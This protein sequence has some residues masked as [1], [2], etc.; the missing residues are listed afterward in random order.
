MFWSFF[1]LFSVLLSSSFQFDIRITLLLR[2]HFRDVSYCSISYLKDLEASWTYSKN[3]KFVSARPHFAYRYI[4]LPNT[5]IS[6]IVAVVILRPSLDQ[7]L[8]K[9][10]VN[11][12]LIGFPAFSFRNAMLP[13][14]L[15][16]PAHQHHV[17]AA[18]GKLERLL[19]DRISWRRRL[20]GRPGSG[21]RAHC[22]MWFVLHEKVPLCAQR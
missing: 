3:L 16:G 17:P 20:G 2:S 10:D 18:K 9:R 19:R 11:S 21:R 15:G 4:P 12:A 5:P 7:S 14:C 22:R 13:V 8:P 1:R 6:H